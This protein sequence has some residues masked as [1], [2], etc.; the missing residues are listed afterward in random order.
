MSLVIMRS[1]HQH[2][3]RAA[4]AGVRIMLGVRH[5]FRLMTA[6]VGTTSMFCAHLAP[7]A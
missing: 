2:S 1:G 7:T 5:T 6:R 4:N 3:G